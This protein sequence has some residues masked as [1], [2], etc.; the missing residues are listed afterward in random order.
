[1]RMLSCYSS[2]QGL[3]DRADGDGG[4]KVAFGVLGC[5]TRAALRIAG[6]VVPLHIEA[7]QS[8]AGYAISSHIARHGKD[9]HGLGSSSIEP[10]YGL[11]D[12]LVKARCGDAR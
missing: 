11:T 7:R 10:L 4:R 1:M 3:I 8:A 12:A 9:N 5:P 6:I 2:E